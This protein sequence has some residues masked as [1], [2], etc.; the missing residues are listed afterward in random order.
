MFLNRVNVKIALTFTLFST[1]VS[2][3]IFSALSLLISRYIKSEDIKQLTYQLDEFEAKYQ[4]GGLNLITAGI[5][6]S[7]MH[8]EGKPYFIR[9]MKGVSK[10]HMGP[11]FWKNSFNYKLLDSAES[12]KLVTLS[13]EKF[14]F[15]L[16]V[17]T[18][19]ISD[20]TI[21]QIGISD[22]HRRQF[23]NALKR[24]FII[25]IIPL[26]F[27]SLIFGFWYAKRTLK[28]VTDLTKTITGI[29]KTGKMEKKIQ[30]S[31]SDNELSELTRLFT[32]LF[33][34]NENLIIGMKETLD[35]VSHDLR[36]PLTRI[37]GISEV[38]LTS[39]DQNA[40]QEAL[41]DSIEE[42]D[43]IIKILNALLDITASE[44][45]VLNLDN[46]YFNIQQ[47]IERSIE[48]YSFIAESKMI[49][50]VLK[51]STD[52]TEY[53]G[54]ETR[55]RQVISNLMDNAV[56]YS[57]LSG[58]ITIEVNSNS[59]NFIIK[60]TDNGIGIT[61]DEIHNIW[62]RLFRSTRSRKE[63]GLG[64]GLSMVKAIVVA[65]GGE[66]S[67]ESIINSGS[68]FTITLPLQ[69]SNERE[70]NK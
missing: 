55:L 56:K 8:H 59:D 38:A 52:I 70:I 5:D 46:S 40:Q 12:G 24:V 37:R 22:Q 4:K 61:T 15:D 2:I 25:L 34:K 11:T 42:I 26:F 18:Y 41:S 66:V 6:I 63:P 19:K 13:S 69:K 3:I 33:E 68:T 14:D 21:F 45:G 43:S 23:T 32:T 7:N 44:N 35:N 60:V 36:T 58:I 27:T 50:F 17:L 49:N 9:L 28:P 57:K 62:N 16:D 51:Y 53:Y 64:L 39:G 1:L 65:H 67:V 10:F 29:I 30:V 31:N 47:L 20:G 48:L 54:D